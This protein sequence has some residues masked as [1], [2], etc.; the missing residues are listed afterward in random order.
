MCA[1]FKRSLCTHSLMT[2]IRVEY[3][4]SKC[5][6]AGECAK[7]AAKFFSLENNKKAKLHN[8]KKEGALSC[9]EK[10]CTTPEIHELVAA[11]RNC[12]TNAI[13][14]ADMDNNLELVG[15]RVDVSKAKEIIAKYDDSKDFVLDPAGYFLIRIDE[16]QKQI[17]VGFC[18]ERNKVEVKVIGKH[19]TEI[20]HT[21]AQLHL[22][23]RMEHASYLGRELHK[24]YL[25]LKH[26]KKYVQ[27]DE[28]EF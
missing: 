15:V 11:A 13:R 23:T 4:Q 16:K 18:S 1:S 25:A 5:I 3:D 9:I 21:I 22:I 20:Y 12:P 28:L 27:D 6:G 14:V 17:E 7:R 19:P 2:L 10:K 26:K 8:G 24:A